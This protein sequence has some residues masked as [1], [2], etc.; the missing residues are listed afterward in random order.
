MAPGGGLYLLTSKKPAGVV[1]SGEKETI[2]FDIGKEVALNENICVFAPSITLPDAIT[3]IDFTWYVNNEAKTTGATKDG[4][5]FYIAY[6][7]SQPSAVIGDESNY[8]THYLVKAGTTLFTSSTANYVLEHDYNFW[9]TRGQNLPFAYIFQHGGN[10][11][12]GGT[13]GLTNGNINSLK[14]TTFGGGIQDF[15]KRFLF[16]PSY[17]ETSEAWTY[18]NM[19]WEQRCPIYIDKGNGYELSADSSKSP[20]IWENGIVENNGE[21]LLFS[22]YYSEVFGDFSTFESVTT[23]ERS[24]YSFYIPNGT[25]WGGIDHPFMIEGDTYF[26]IVKNASLGYFHGFF[27][28]PHDYEL[29]SDNYYKCTRATH[30]DENEYFIKNADGT[31]TDI[32]TYVTSANSW[33]SDFLSKTA[34]PCEN[35]D[36]NSFKSDSEL[37]TGFNTS[38]TA[39]SD[40]AKEIIKSNPY[41][42]ETIK[43]AIDRYNFIIGKYKLTDFIFGSTS[44]GSKTIT[45]MPVSND[46][47]LLVTII[48][49]IG[50]SSISGYLLLRKKKQ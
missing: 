42:D 16:Q 10:E 20:I 11:H 6:N 44:S 37:W 26:E 34:T 28:T 27:T 41:G 46:V 13:I 5:N 19:G 24:Y 40:T 32:S 39:L 38:Y 22:L 9:S 47:I 33:A 36:A 15:A 17:E 45:R 50:I 49:I 1:A 23:M 4:D 3:P 18:G 12:H 30:A 25:L 29:V 31:Y 35:L 8:Y 43:D 14:F 2:Y 21:S 7:G 48:A